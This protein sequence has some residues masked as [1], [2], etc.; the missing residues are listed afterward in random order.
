MAY[1]SKHTGDNIDA[2]ISI[3]D[4]QN[5]RLTA[6]E[7]KD[8]ILQNN[9]DTINTNLNSNMT[10]FNSTITNLQSQIAQLQSAMESLQTDINILNSYGRIAN[11]HTGEHTIS[12]SFTV[13]PTVTLNGNSN[14]VYLSNG[15]IYFNKTG[16]YK[17]TLGARW[18]D[19]S[20][21]INCYLGFSKNGAA[22][23][24]G[25]TSGTWLTNGQRLVHN[26]QYFSNITSGDY[27]TFIGYSDSSQTIRTIYFSIEYIANLY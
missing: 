26:V 7:N 14:F 2:G 3:N 19:S 20:G 6:L 10:T 5:N 27:I 18:S 4:T 25:G 17:I 22:A 12:T 13:I 23:D 24:G 9:I 8:T 21:N 11:G 16:L 1:Q 15:K